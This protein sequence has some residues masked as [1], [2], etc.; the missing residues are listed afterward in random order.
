MNIRTVNTTSPKAQPDW[1][2]LGF[3]VYYTDHMLMIDYA[4][5]KGW[6]DA[7]I[8]P[9][10]PLSMDPSAMVLHYAVEIFEGLKAY[11]TPDGKI[12]MFRPYDNAKRLNVSAA[13]FCMPDLPVDDFMD[14]ICSL[15]KLERAWVPKEEGTSL[16]I[17]PF[18]YSDQPN[19]GVRI[20]ELFKFVVILSPVGAYYKEGIN[21]VS[22]YVEDEYVRAAKGGTGYTKCGGN[23]A[24]SLIAQKK[25][26]DMGCTQVLWLDG[27]ERK[28][29]EEVGTMNVIF[30]INGEIVT[31]ELS[32]SILAGI[33]R[34]S[35]LTLLRHWDYKV[36]ERKISKDELFN[37]AESGALEEAFGTGTAAVISPIGLF[38]INGKK[39]PV[40]NGKIGPVA[41]K[42][43]DTITGI[44]W[45]K[46]PDPFGWTY[47]VI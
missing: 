1:N 34:D 17:R 9:Y 2:N 33:T 5:G 3:G 13:R 21:P 46:I 14:S 43:Y 23:Y 40:N 16:Y 20:P 47:E 44:Q 12:K 24:A 35:V 15:I 27:A 32:D 36:S 18:M 8:V 11:A 30:K 22:I 37:A 7:R 42:L 4:A 28:Y 39:I 45:G 29:I 26:S 38:D 41:Q 31:P 25:A 6:H 19:V 10:G